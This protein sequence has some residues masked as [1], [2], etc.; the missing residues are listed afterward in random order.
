MKD[1]CVCF[2][3]YEEHFLQGAVNEYCNIVCKQTDIHVNVCS[4][5]VVNGKC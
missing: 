5:F 2:H 3:V 1:A 4:Q